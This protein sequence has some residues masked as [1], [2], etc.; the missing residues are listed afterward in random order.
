MKT[1]KS[2]NTFAILACCLLLIAL[3]MRCHAQGGINVTGGVNVTGAIGIAAGNGVTISSGGT[4]ALGNDTLTFANGAWVNNGTFDSGTSTVSFSGTS[5]ITGA[6]DFYNLSVTGGTT[7][8]NSG[9]TVGGA[10]AFGG[11]GGITTGSDTLILTNPTNAISGAGSSNYVNGNMQVNFPTNSGTQT[12]KYEIGDASVYAPVTLDMRNVDISG[13]AM[14]VT[15]YITSGDTNESY[16]SNIDQIKKANRYW[17]LTQSGNGS[18]SNYDITLDFTNTTNGGTTGNYIMKKFDPFTWASTTSS[19]TS[20]TVSLKTI[21]ATNLTNFSDFE[22]GE[23]GIIVFNMSMFIQGY[24]LGSGKMSPL[25]KL[26]GTAGATWSDVDTITVELHRGT[27]PYDSLYASKGVLED[28]GSLTCSFPGTASGSYYVVIKG[29][30]TLETWS[31]SA[32]IISNPYNFTT[33]ANQ[34]YGSN[35]ADLK[36]GNFAI[37]S[38]DINQDGYINASD[39]A[40]LQAEIP[41]FHFGIPYLNDV[42]GDGFVDEDDYRILQ[43]NTPLNISVQHP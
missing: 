23:N 30:N 32:V 9:T 41:L 15:G 14:N 38:G 28:D 25:L 22:I 5:N 42:T 27:S 19:V 6:T 13:G 12:F 43:N 7:T 1:I 37:Y 11:S 29:R 8:I 39:K 33:S 35:Q 2:N 21:K 36:D 17:V 40:L 4:L 26:L 16:G 24:Y 10:L 20:N 34:A 31:A 18:F 3:S